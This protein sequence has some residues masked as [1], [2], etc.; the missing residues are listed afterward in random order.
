MN[1]PIT[2]EGH[3]IAIPEKLAYTKREVCDLFGIS[4]MTLWRW[5]HLGRI[6]SVPGLGSVKIYPRSEIERF[7]TLPAATKAPKNLHGHARVGK[8]QKRPP[9]PAVGKHLAQDAQRSE[10]RDISRNLVDGP[11]TT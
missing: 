8:R 3:S 5:E 10:K 6:R 7:L 11:A 9:S 2:A 4:V 1:T